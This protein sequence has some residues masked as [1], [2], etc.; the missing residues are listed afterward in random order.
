MNHSKSA[1]QNIIFDLGGVLIDLD[2]T[3]TVK[4]FSDLD[5]PI[6]ADL[7]EIERRA[8]MYRGLE[9]GT[10]SPGLFREA[11][12]ELSPLLPSDEAID[13]AWN[14][15]LSDFPEKRVET[16]QKLKGNYRV[17]LLSNSNAIHY[18][19]YRNRF[20]RDYA[21]E[22]NSLFEQAYYS[23]EMNICKPQ[24]EIFQKVLVQSGLRAEETLFIDDTADNVTAASALGIL[25]HQIM[26]GQDM[27]DLFSDGLLI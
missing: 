4:A 5:I 19:Y 2:V 12:R 3:R 6:P 25:T 16:L 13:N 14:A 24:P 17:F 26:P 21:I 11:I 20:K 22:M 18:Q 1:I 9:T 8:V 10:L 23:F 27:V 7:A 15:M